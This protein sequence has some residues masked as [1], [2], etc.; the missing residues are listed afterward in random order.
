MQRVAAANMLILENL[1]GSA[2][3]SCDKNETTM[4][5]EI[6]ND[7]TQTYILGMLN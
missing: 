7:G 4:V 5:S 1:N 3:E 6:E 2:N